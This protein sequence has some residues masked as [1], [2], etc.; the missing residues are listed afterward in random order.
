MIRRCWA[1]EH[2]E[3]GRGISRE[4]YVSQGIFDQE[5]IFVQGFDWCKDKEMKI[6]LQSASAR[7]LCGV[8]NNR[9]SQ[10][11][12]GGIAAVRRFEQVSNVVDVDLET[13]DDTLALDGHLFER[14]L[15]K[16]AINISFGCNQHIGVGMVSAKTG[17][18]PAYLLAVVFGN[19]LFTHKMGAYF[20]YPSSEY[21]IQKGKISIMPI[22]K[23]GQIGGFYFHLR[24]IDVFLSLYP[25][26]APLRLGELGITVLPKHLLNADVCYR[27]YSIITTTNRGPS[28][29]I[30]FNWQ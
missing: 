10:A 1:K 21:I 20:L 19:I 28:T 29:V 16:T 27:P 9:L 8:H 2:S 30:R 6:G 26:H 23:G 15:L 5:S 13:K 11:D 24:G 25:G 17:W 18:P 3:C 12:C 14:W 4:H 22:Y 7:I